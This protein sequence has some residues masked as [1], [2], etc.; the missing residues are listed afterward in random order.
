LIKKY[1]S[2]N[3]FFYCDPPYTI[4]E[5]TGYYNIIFDCDDHSRLHDVLSGIEGKV[6]IS[7]DNAPTVK[8]MYCT[9]NIEKVPLRYQA[10]KTTLDDT[11]ELLISNFEQKTLMDYF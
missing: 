6:L 8:K 5:D 10:K 4:A 9:W 2:P 7:Y 3:T 11:F 1:D